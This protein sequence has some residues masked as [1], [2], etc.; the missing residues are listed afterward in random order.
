MP[1][2]AA[3]APSART[4][5]QLSDEDIDLFAQA[6]ALLFVRHADDFDDFC[7]STCERIDQLM[8]AARPNTIPR[9][10]NL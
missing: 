3:P 6:I 5:S 10:A 4:R 7:Q 2:I 8:T 9:P 1:A